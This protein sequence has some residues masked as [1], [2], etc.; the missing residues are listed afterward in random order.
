MVL[1]KLNKYKV[2]QYTG[3]EADN[4]SA[5]LGPDSTTEK[6][7]T[8]LQLTKEEGG[9]KEKKKGLKLIPVFVPFN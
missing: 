8:T 5:R 9:K 4:Q 3:W 7:H 6:C 2:D 1:W